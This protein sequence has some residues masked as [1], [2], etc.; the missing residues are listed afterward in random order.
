MNGFLGTEAPF[1]SDLSL[2]ITIFLGG[3]AAYGGIQA[4][5]KKFY[6]HCPVMA[7]AVF[8]NWIPVMVVMVPTFIDV[9]Q[10]SETLATGLFANVPIVHGI[11][12][13]ITQ[14]LMTYTVTRMYWIESLPP[15]EPIW[16]MRTTIILWLLTVTGGVG[17][18]TMAN[19]L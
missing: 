4:H 8:L 1:L 6:K 7:Y 2:I 13:T 9:L 18:Y 19:I 17:L 12:G 5:K 3:V 10:G 11:L 15:R 14:L 16:L